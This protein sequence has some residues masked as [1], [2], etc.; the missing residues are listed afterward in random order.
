MAE[1]AKLLMFCSFIIVASIEA[2][3]ARL[4]GVLSTWSKSRYANMRNLAEELIRRNNEVC[5]NVC[6]ALSLNSEMTSE[7]ADSEMVASSK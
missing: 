6:N 5:K 7:S 2:N 1:H 3:G 4:I